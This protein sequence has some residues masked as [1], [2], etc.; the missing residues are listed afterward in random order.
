MLK[1]INQ[2]KTQQE[3]NGKV[4]IK[5]FRGAGVCD[6]THLNPH[7]KRSLTRGQSHLIVHVGT[8]DIRSKSPDEIVS[9]IKQLG[10]VITEESN[11]TEFIVSEIIARNGDPQLTSTVNECN[12]KLDELCTRLNLGLIKHNN[13]CKIHLNNYLNHRGTGLFAGQNKKTIH[14]FEI[15]M[16]SRIPKQ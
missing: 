16:R 11:D 5:I 8:N 6:M 14:L 10:E 9:A 4:K 3:V 2:R 1:Y 7:I 15:R 12:S 13:S